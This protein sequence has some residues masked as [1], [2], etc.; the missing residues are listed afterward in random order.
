MRVPKRR[1]PKPHSCS[2]SKSPRRQ[3]AAA[4]PNQVIRPNSNTKIVSATQFTSCT[5]IL[6]SRV[7]SYPCAVIARALKLFGGLKID[8]GREHGADDHPE[9]LEPIEERNPREVGL[10]FIVN[11]RPQGNGKLHHEEQVPPAPP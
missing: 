11:G 10:G 8:D 7:L 3:R 9:Q 6:S 5:M 2:R 1:P 4:K